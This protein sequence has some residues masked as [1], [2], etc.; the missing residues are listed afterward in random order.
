[1]IS[2][3]QDNESHE[4]YER[5]CMR[6]NL[7]KPYACD[8]YIHGRSIRSVSQRNRRFLTVCFYNMNSDGFRRQ[9]EILRSMYPNEDRSINWSRKRKLDIQRDVKKL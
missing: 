1:M 2:V 6:Y 7:L 4:S 8:I 5:T 9:L 3:N